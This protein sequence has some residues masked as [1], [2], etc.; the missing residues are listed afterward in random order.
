MKTFYIIVSLFAIILWGIALL[1]T[2][3]LI[4]NNFPLNFIT[5]SRFCFVTPGFRSSVISRAY[6]LKW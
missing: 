1:A 4:E 3:V 2:R 6:I 5:I